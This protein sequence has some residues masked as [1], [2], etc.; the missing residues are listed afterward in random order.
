VCRDSLPELRANAK[1]WSEKP[2]VLVTVNVDK[3]ESDWQGYEEIAALTLKHPPRGLLS[4]RLNNGQ[5]APIKLPTLV[6]VDGKGQVRAHY[7][8]RVEPEAW[9]KVAELLP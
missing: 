6:V 4:V 1:G 7:E 8:G 3:H 9:D 5:P 2:F